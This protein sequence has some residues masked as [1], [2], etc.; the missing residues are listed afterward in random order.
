[1]RLLYVSWFAA[2]AE[3]LVSLPKPTRRLLPLRRA[4]EEQVDPNVREIVSAA[5][6][7]TPAEVAA[8]AIALSERVA[9]SEAAAAASAASPPTSSHFRSPGVSRSSS[10]RDPSS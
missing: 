10:Q 5:M 4:E 2:W 9:A 1:M 8:K 3:A 6:Y 7:G